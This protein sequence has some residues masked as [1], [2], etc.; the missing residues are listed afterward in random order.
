MSDSWLSSVAWVAR[1]VNRWQDP[2][3]TAWTHS[4]FSANWQQGDDISWASNQ[5][6]RKNTTEQG[7]VEEADTHRPGLAVPLLK[8][9]QDILAH[10]GTL[11]KAGLHLLGL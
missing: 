10:Q 6:K 5:R 3:E 11:E 8:P 7:Q 2:Q 9:K 1:A 4:L